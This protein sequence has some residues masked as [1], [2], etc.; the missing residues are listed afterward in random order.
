MQ[1]RLFSVR[2]DCLVIPSISHPFMTLY[3]YQQKKSVNRNINND[4]D[5]RW[6]VNKLIRLALQNLSSGQQLGI[7]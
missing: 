1:I 3:R 5:L 2:D 7:K 4:E 6:D